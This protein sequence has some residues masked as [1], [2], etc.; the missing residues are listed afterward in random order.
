MSAIMCRLDCKVDGNGLS[1]Y[2]IYDAAE[3]EFPF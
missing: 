3:G 1:H 2:I